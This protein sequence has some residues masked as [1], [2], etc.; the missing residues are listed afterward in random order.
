MTLTRPKE[1]PI[2]FA[3]ASS[4]QLRLGGT[5]RPP[6]VDPFQQHRQLCRRQHRHALLGSRPDEAP[7][8]QPLSEQAQ[9]I[10]I[11]PQQLQKIAAATAKAE[12][13]TRERV[14][15]QHCLRLR[16]QT[17]EA[18]AHVGHARRQPHPS[19]RSQANHRSSSITWRSTAGT[20]SPRRLTRAPLP[21]SISMVPLR[22]F[23]RPC[24]DR[25]GTISTGTIVLAA[26]TDG[27]AFGNNSRRHL[28]SW[29][30]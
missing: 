4:G 16:R 10:A 14:L 18:L 5:D 24:R 29:L 2:H 17:V 28:N 21:N 19:A 13:M 6:P 9:P 12:N 26:T 30:V 8:L 1:R 27:T 23:R 3:A 20:T 22:S 25:S 11:P 7:S 15:A